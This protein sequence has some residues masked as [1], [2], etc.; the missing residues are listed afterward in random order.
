MEIK[1]VAIE[2]IYRNIV[3]VFITKGET[4]TV[5][6]AGFK[7]EQGKAQIEAALREWNYTLSDVEQV[8][9]THHHPD[10]CGLVD[11][12]PNAQ[13]V[14]HA[15]CNHFLQ[16]TDAF[17]AYYEQYHI[18]LLE[19]HG[20]F[21]AEQLLRD[22]LTTDMPHFGQKP[23]TKTLHHL[24]DVPGMPGF[25]A[26]YT[27]GHCQSHFMF[28]NEQSGISFG[29]D[30]ILDTI[31]PNP[32][33]EPPLDLSFRRDSS[34]LLYHESLRHVANLHIDT[35]YTGHGA[36]IQHVATR[37]GEIRAQQYA[38]AMKVLSFFEQGKRYRAPHI[39]KLL[40]GP[41]FQKQP[42]LTLSETLGQ[43]DFLVHERKISMND[44][45]QIYYYIGE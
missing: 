19:Q 6:D 33:V 11:I 45:Q 15:Y 24:D 14:G 17:I 20:I 1:Q 5:V 40:F 30:L 21:G 32:F 7:S 23:V 2:T 12:F 3:N 39:T 18:Q 35:L 22:F 29:G 42:A 31:S 25:V 43:L 9:L 41:V 10:H 34:M 16:P 28:V 36:P 44:E 37:I 38:R 8:V 27:P 26:H 13:I 4:L